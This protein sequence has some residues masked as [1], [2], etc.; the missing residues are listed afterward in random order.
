VKRGRKA[1]IV[2][3]PVKRALRKLGGDIADARR[4]RRIPMALMAERASINRV[5]LAKIEKGEPGVS[6]GSYA[7]VLFVLGLTGVLSDLADAIKDSVG[8]ALEEER[9]P[10]RIRT[11]SKR[12]PSPLEPGM[13]E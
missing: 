9:L 4:R 11:P 10:K 6:M 13:E 5:T 7:T 1:A 8:L 3:I 12:K 2:P